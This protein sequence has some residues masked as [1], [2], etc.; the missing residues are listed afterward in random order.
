MADSDKLRPD[1]LELLGKTLL[2]RY[3]LRE[4]LASGGMSVVYRGQDERLQR[5]V[6]VKV[7]FGLD[8]ERIEYQTNYDHFVQEAFALSQLQHP[9]TIR[10]YDF[11][12]LDVEPHSPFYVSEL[13]TGGTLQQRVKREGPLSPLESFDILEP[14]VHALAEAH[15]RGIIHRDIKPSNILFGAA[16]PRRIVKLADFGIAKAQPES[17]RLP[18]RAKDTQAVPGMRISLYSPGWAAPEQ[19][20][21]KKVG[22]TADV[23]S[24]GLL[25]VYMLSG[26]KLFSEDN[27]LEALSNRMEGDAY[28]A[29]ALSV[30]KLP[31]QLQPVVLKACRTDPAERYGSVEELLAA[32]KSSIT[33]LRPPPPPIADEPEPRT[34][35]LAE[36][37]RMRDGA[38]GKGALLLLS[39][40]ADP[41]VV[42]AGRRVRLLPTSAPLDLG[43]DDDGAVQSPAR[44]RITFLP[45][46][47]E[48][49]RVHVKGLNCFVLKEGGRPSSAVDVAE[50]A[51]LELR[52]PGRERLDAV[53]CQFGRVAESGVRLYP[54]A[55]VTL[56]V[57][58]DQAP[59]SVLMDFGPGREMILV[60]SVRP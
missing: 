53:R 10:I 13:M 55:N 3:T 27:V 32:V 23:F 17:E 29:K 1:P 56:G 16:G 54:V 25:L 5:P 58:R 48:G 44:I 34:E 2:G 57:P 9:N 52:S 15:A 60:Y 26:K 20:R 42:A 47:K 19:M 21:G 46:T 37:G 14:V 40:M 7:F 4:K 6:C 30:L 59:H 22:P 33:V 11:G 28:V 51:V 39:S 43:G 31:Q 45:G 8:R 24:L 18:N 35:P 41:E 49:A 50:D 38:E 12:Y 36:P